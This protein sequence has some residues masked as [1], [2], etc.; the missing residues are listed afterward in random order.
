MK[1]NDSPE[2]EGRLREVLAAWRVD[3]TPPPRFQERVWQRIERGE[4]Q[5]TVRPWTA[6]ASWLEQAMARPTLAVSYVTLLLAVGLIGG[7]WQGQLARA[8]AAET[9]SARYVQMVDPYQTPRH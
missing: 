9:L 4:T 2:D 1:A 6:F 7:F 3:A 5:R 8:R